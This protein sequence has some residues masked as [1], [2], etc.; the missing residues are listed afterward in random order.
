MLPDPN[1]EPL[2]IRTLREYRELLEARELDAMARMA[3]SWLVIEHRLDAD[4]LALALE[5]ERR[6]KAG[7]VVTQQMIWKMDRYKILKGKL[8]AEIKIW[9]RDS[10]IPQIEAEQR[11]FGWLGID[12][13]KEAIIASY[14]GPLTAPLF[15]VLNRGA[16]EAM[17]G[18]LGNGSPLNILLKQDYPD[19]IDGLCDALLQG[20]AR[21]Y[22]PG[23]VAN[24]MAD[25]MGM[26]LERAMLIARTEINR[27]YRQANIEAYR[28]SDVVEGFMRLVRK[29]TACMSCLM[30]DG[31]RFKTQD[32]F[33]DHPRGKA[34]LPG[35]LIESSTPD[36]FVTL[37][38]QGDIVIIGTSSGKFLPVTPNHPVLTDRGWVAAKFVKEG[39][40]VLSQSGRYGASG[41]MSPDKNHIPTLVEKIPSAFNMPRLGSVPESAKHLYTNREDGEVDVIF[42]NR[43]L[44]G[45]LDTASKQEIIKHLFGSGHITGFRFPSF[46][47]IAENLVR[48]FSTTRELLRVGNIGASFSLGHL[49][50]PQ[51]SSLGV[52]AMWNAVFSQN[53]GYNVSRNAERLCDSVFSLAG[54][55]AGDNFHGRQGDLIPTLGGEFSGLNRQSFGFSPKQPLSLEMI[56]EGLSRSVPAGSDNLNAIAS[57]VIFDRVTQVDVRY[58]SGHVYSLQT[59]E[60]WYSSNHIISHNCI[61][62]PFV[63]GVKPPVW[64]TGSEWFMTL[65]PE[66]QL[67]KMG[68]EYFEAWQAGQ[69]KLEDLAKM[70]HSPV[71]GDSPMVTPLKELIG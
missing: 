47:L 35:N 6:L 9:N 17:V 66:E 23:Q 39:D 38:H 15:P 68:S 24:M 11:A 41:V 54:G 28:A 2:V 29:G 58:F 40:N 43:F 3:K 8:Q 71:W 69:F 26:G 60:G 33:S 46:G 19:A 64:Q 21:G 22:G 31:Q 57:D 56:R 18:Y 5:T 30:L 48:M 34:E 36:A 49:G 67:A 70:K 45:G 32:D 4:I 10:L 59:K 16:V 37:Y 62:V 52:I 55:V 20:I 53:S 51:I 42:A 14:G 63:K 1:L 13:G 12:A 50:E 25:G 65:S 61:A 44:W 27:A 7:E